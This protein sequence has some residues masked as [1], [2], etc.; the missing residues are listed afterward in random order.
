MHPKIYCRKGQKVFP[1]IC[2][3]GSAVLDVILLAAVVVFLILPV[4]YSVIE[5]HMILTKTQIMKIAVDMTNVSTYE[6]IKA[7]SLSGN[8]VE[9]D[10]ALAHAI[11]RKLLAKNLNLYD[12][13]SPKPESVADDKVLID[14]LFIYTGGTQA[15]C[16]NGT[17]LERP[18]VHGCITIPVK[19]SLYRHIILGQAEKRYFELKIHVDSEIPVDN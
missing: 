4:F 7:Q 3:K 14:S 1:K 15:F 11:Y 5:R 13:L 9:I 17:R 10:Y 16:P 12:D 18:S 2:R 19:P 6:A 8:R